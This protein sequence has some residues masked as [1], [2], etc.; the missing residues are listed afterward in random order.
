MARLLVWARH[1]AGAWNHVLVPA[2]HIT[3]CTLLL[4]HASTQ[5]KG[6]PVRFCAPW[7]V[8]ITIQCFK[9]RLQTWLHARGRLVPMGHRR[10]HMFFSGPGKG[11]HVLA[12]TKAAPAFESAATPACAAM[13]GL[14]C[15][16]GSSASDGYREFFLRPAARLRSPQLPTCCICSSATPRRQR[17]CGGR[18][19]IL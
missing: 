6:S 19:C 9:E 12:L 17:G 5:A 13:V 4:L 1:W 10:W 2:R 18:H 7:T 16:H 3:G 11:T 8:R 15:C 14:S